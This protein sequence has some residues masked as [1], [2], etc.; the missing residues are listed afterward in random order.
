MALTCSLKDFPL[1]NKKR[2]RK[3]TIADLN[4]IVALEN[5]FFSVDAFNRRQFRS[6]ITK[7]NS[8]VFLLL[9][10]EK[11]IGHCVTLLKRLVNHATKGRI[12]SIGVSPDH[13]SMGH[14]QFMVEYMERY[15]RL[16]NISHVT[17]ECDSGNNRL[18]QFYNRNGYEMIERLPEYYADGSDAVRMRKTL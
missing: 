18:I 1:K 14:G 13:Q 4:V 9:E 8:N 7:P 11:P 10:N 2:I 6:L 3:A 16:K 15:F 12:Y 5:S 17:L